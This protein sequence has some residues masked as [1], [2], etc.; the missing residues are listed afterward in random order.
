MSST[1]LATTV[2]AGMASLSH[3]SA[4]A[5]RIT[6]GQQAI[7]G[8]FAKGTTIVIDGAVD[9]LYPVRR[10][11]QRLG[12]SHAQRD[13]LD[14]TLLAAAARGNRDGLGRAL[15]NERRMSKPTTPLTR[16]WLERLGDAEA[17][18]A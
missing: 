8:D 15:L 18:R 11:A 4:T 3:S 16:H 7:D 13:L 17:A 9:A 10:L 1:P 6:G 12:G 5:F 14:Q 2:G